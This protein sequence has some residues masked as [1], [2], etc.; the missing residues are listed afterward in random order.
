[1]IKTEFGIID[2][3]DKRNDYTA[4][5]PQQYHCVAIDDD[6]YLNDWQEKLSCLNTF[7]VYKKGVLQPQT[8]LSRW[9]ITIIP[10]QSLPAFLNIVITDKRYDIDKNLK[11]LESTIR[12]AIDQ[13]KHMIHFGI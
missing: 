1:M 8:A 7:N 2:K 4:Y 3:F 13:E 5:S 11:M 9:G 12:K 6:L 10:P